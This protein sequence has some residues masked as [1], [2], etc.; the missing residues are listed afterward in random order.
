MRY[1][2]AIVFFLFFTSFLNNPD[3]EGGITRHP[4]KTKI[5]IGGDV[6]FDWGL[7]A[8]MKKNG[9]YSPVEKL[10]PIFE[11]SDFRMVNLETTVTHGLVSP[12]KI[13][14]Y[15]FNSKPEEMNL[16]KYLNIDHVFLANNHSMDYGPEGLLETIQIL[17]DY[18]FSFSG[19]GT[20]YSDSNQPF[21]FQLK[22][23][24]IL[25]YSVSAIGEQRL[26]ATK[27][28]PGASSYNPKRLS[29]LIKESNNTINILSV[30]W[31]IEYSPE[32]TPSQRFD[33]K[34]LIQSGFKIIIGHHPHIPQGIEKIDDGLVIYSLGNFI[35]GSKNQ[36]LNHNILIKLI[37]EDSK[38]VTCEI[39]PVFGKFQ[40]SPHIIYPLEGK[41]ALDFLNEI[42]YMSEKLNTKIEIKNNKGYINF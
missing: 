5:L 33:A 14:P 20:N 31:G 21:Q 24:N 27:N 18:G 32:P 15:V 13:K 19:A 4:K 2:T 11:D 12:D 39:I 1:S 3:L 29:S 35:F 42:S 38:L 40:S 34:Q 26:F 9:F 7:R 16:L 23:S 36:Y 22:Q 30:H 28:S 10:L 17:K 25:L 37:L 6:M 8:T 41:E